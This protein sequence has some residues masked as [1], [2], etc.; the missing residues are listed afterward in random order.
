MATI[1]VSAAPAAVGAVNPD[2]FVI[3]Y[4]FPEQVITDL[5]CFL[6]KE[7]LATGSAIFRGTIVDAGDDGFHIS[8]IEKFEETLVPVDGQGPTYVESGGVTRFSF[9]IRTASG[10]GTFTRVNNDKYFGFEGGRVV[11]AATIRV[12]ELVRFAA[13]DT[14][15]DGMPDVVKVEF[16]K[17]DFSCP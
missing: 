15:G 5:P 2:H 1:G 16:Y 17:A 9:N 11:S 4:Q 6:G 10:V 13:D 7:F 14:D 3:E 8:Q 12:H